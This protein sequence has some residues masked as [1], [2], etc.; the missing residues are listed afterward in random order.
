MEKQ[1]LFAGLFPNLYYIE[2]AATAFTQFAVSFLSVSY[3][4]LKSPLNLHF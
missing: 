3:G 1:S 2:A 4:A